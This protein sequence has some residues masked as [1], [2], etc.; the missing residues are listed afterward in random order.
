MQ[1]NTHDEAA[2]GCH[3][4]EAAERTLCK[5]GTFEF[6]TAIMYTV[7]ISVQKCTV[8]HHYSLGPTEPCHK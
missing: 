7:W 1:P 3:A 2:Q 4:E 8:N 6:H 5:S